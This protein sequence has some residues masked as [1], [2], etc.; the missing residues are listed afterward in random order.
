[1]LSLL[2]KQIHCLI[3]MSLQ[4]LNCFCLPLERFVSFVTFRTFRI[5]SGFQHSTIFTELMLPS[6]LKEPGNVRHTSSKKY[7]RRKECMCTSYTFIH[8]E[9][10]QVIVFFCCPYTFHK[11]VCKKHIKM[12][13]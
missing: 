11:I 8:T 6:W 1:M 12:Y 4:A 2:P 5:E 7:N 13:L 3:E 10:S 9:I